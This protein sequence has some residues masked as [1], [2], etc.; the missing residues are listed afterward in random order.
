MFV[1]RVFDIVVSGVL[2]ILTLPVMALIGLLVKLDSCGSAVFMQ[3]RVGMN[4]RRA[5]AL[6]KDGMNHERERRKRDLGG[7]AFTMYKF[8]SMV[9]EAEKMLPCLVNLGGLS[10]PVYKL[11]ND[12]RVTRF[13]RLIRK[14]SLDELPQLFNVL[15]GDMSLVGPRPEALRV[16][17][18]YGEKH[19]QRLQTKPG[20]TGL[21]QVTCRGTKSMAQRLEYDLHYI[22]H[23]SLY[24]D[25]LIFFKTFFVVIR[26]N[27]AR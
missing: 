17:E 8:R 10:E 21:Q 5:K 19:R 9:Q 4:R 26:G 14:T 24:L 2:I 6:K 11:D 23:H 7:R 25:F 15:K 27:G 12:P 16:V 3:T 13:G 1:K 22:K 20:L 18:L